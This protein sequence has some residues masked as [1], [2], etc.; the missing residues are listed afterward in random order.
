VQPHYRLK[1]KKEMAEHKHVVLVN[2]GIVQRVNS[3]EATL[4]PFRGSA[5][6]K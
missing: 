4:K 6:E 5:G 2:F 1:K 3:R